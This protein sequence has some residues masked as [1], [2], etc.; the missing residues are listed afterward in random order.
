[1]DAPEKRVVVAM[2]GGVDSS[3]AAALL[4][5]QGYRVHGLHLKIAP[6]DDPSDAEA[7]ARQLGIP[8]ECVELQVG[9]DRLAQY[10]CE[11]YDR[12]RTPNPCVLCNC[13]VKFASLLR[14]AQQLGAQHIATG[15]Y[16]RLAK[17]GD[18]W[19]I[20]RGIDPQKDQSYVLSRLTQEQLTTLV[21]PLGAR[22]KAEVRRLARE[23]G[24]HVVD[25][26]ES[27]EVCFVPDNDTPRFLIQRLAERV[28]PG[29]IID[30]AGNVVGRHRGVQLYTIGQRKGLGAHGEPRYVVRIDA[31]ANRIAIGPAEALLRDRMRVADINWM[32]VDPP[33]EP[34]RAAV[35]IRYLH[36]AAPARIE[37]LDGGAN[38]FFDQPQRSITPGQAAVFYDED[39]VLGGGWIE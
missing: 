28:R 20:R 16:A 39:T 13:V 25:R 23:R 3:V 12:G 36:Q 8:F 17:V 4:L 2:S 37:P 33:R 14:I 15:H 34:F 10:F 35:Q 19:A 31:S 29:E 30:A 21:L 6:D 22:T 32:A 1:M 9:Y 7:V 5:E 24:L 26:A 38:V 11:E 27:Q 18:R